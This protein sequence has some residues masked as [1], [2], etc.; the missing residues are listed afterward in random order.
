MRKAVNKYYR[1]PP[2]FWLVY[3]KDDN[4]GLWYKVIRF[5]YAKMSV[6]YNLTTFNNI[7]LG[8]FTTD[9][10]LTYDSLTEASEDEQEDE[11]EESDSVSS[12]SVVSVSSD[13]SEESCSVKYCAIN[14]FIFL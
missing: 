3:E 13:E 1:C 11:A 6:K 7:N 5:M 9:Q 14:L 8:I 10:A 2:E 4:D 12:C